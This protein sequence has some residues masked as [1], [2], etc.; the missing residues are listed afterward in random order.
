MRLWY[1]NVKCSSATSFF[2]EIYFQRVLYF[3]SQLLQ[4]F[5]HLFGPFYFFLT[6]LIVISIHPS[7]WRQVEF[8]LPNTNC[9]WL[10]LRAQLGYIIKRRVI[11]FLWK[12][13]MEEKI[14]ALKKASPYILARRLM[15]LSR[16]AAAPTPASAPPCVSSS[17]K[18][19]T[20]THKEKKKT[21]A[22]QARRKEHMHIHKH[23]GYTK[24]TTM[25][26]NEKA[27]EKNR[28]LSRGLRS[29]APRAPKPIESKQKRERIAGPPPPEKLREPH[30][31]AFY[32]F[33]LPFAY[34]FSIQPTTLLR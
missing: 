28:C 32:F 15:Q 20:H 26:K 33:L 27:H 31:H 34:G 8:F 1:S 14:Y 22:L 6:S 4:F 19:E 13:R 29:I 9:L 30:T 23:I 12:R 7:I 3:M 2:I 18:W 24:K 25:G 16:D 10:R 11:E 21:Y 5:L 17:S